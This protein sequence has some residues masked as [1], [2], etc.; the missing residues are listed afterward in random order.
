M[1]TPRA[2]KTPPESPLLVRK[3][4]RFNRPTAD[5]S[6]ILFDVN[7]ML[8]PLAEIQA[9]VGADGMFQPEERLLILRYARHLWGL[10]ENE[11][12]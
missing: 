1:R 12:D 11:D 10:K 5:W 2:T 7:N 3:R 4:K 6:A 8:R 9:I